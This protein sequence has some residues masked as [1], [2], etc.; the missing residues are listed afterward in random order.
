MLFTITVGIS[1]ASIL[2]SDVSGIPALCVLHPVSN[3]WG[4]YSGGSLL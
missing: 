2:K 3:F 1:I 4:V